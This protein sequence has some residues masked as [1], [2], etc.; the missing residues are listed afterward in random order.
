[1]EFKSE[2][3]ASAARKRAAM[4]IDDKT[5]EMPGSQSTKPM[6]PF[7]ASA[8]ADPGDRVPGRA[9]G[10]RIANEP[11]GQNLGVAPRPGSKDKGKTV[12]NVI[13]APQGGQPPAMPMPVPM[14]PPSG[15]AGIPSVADKPNA[16]GLPM[17]PGGGAPMPGPMPARA[18]GGRV[19]KF[20]GGAASG[21]G[22]LE[23]AEHAK[24]ERGESKAEEKVE[25]KA[26]G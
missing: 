18:V 13:V 8:K 24:H 23:K 6:Q 15:P 9:M 20:T 11:A 1:M 25:H 7:G 21:V 17:T 14:P 12:V 2:A 4:C 22:R 16:A 10:G 26:K 19:G 3:K 5:D